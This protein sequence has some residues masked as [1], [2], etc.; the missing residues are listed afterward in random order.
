MPIVWMSRIVQCQG[1]VPPSRKHPRLQFLFK[2]SAIY[3]PN[4]LST[5]HDSHTHAGS[6]PSPEHSMA[7]GVARQQQPVNNS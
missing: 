4:H 6:L 3:S 2:E 5:T 1:I 7:A